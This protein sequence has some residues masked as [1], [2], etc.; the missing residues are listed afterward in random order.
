MKKSKID[1]L[2]KNFSIFSTLMA[3]VLVVGFG[4]VDQH[5]GIAG[6]CDV[7]HSGAKGAAAVT[8]TAKE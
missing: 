5:R 7:V 1:G 6:S 3:V 8:A 2:T 4:H